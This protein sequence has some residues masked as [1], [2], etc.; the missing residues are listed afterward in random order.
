MFCEV[1][2]TLYTYVG[3]MDYLQAGNLTTV[4]L[5]RDVQVEFSIT[6]LNDDI[7][8]QRDERFNVALLPREDYE[9]AELNE[10]AVFIEDEDGQWGAE[11][12]SPL[13]NNLVVVSSALLLLLAALILSLEMDHYDVS[14]GDGTVTVHAVSSHPAV[15]D[16]LVFMLVADGSAVSEYHTLPT[17]RAPLYIEYSGPLYSTVHCGRPTYLSVIERCPRSG[18]YTASYTG[19]CVPP[20]Y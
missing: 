5:E 18:S 7:P 15:N 9:V 14:E 3:G 13:F 11:S 8:E 10:A 16:T 1:F 19:D 2:L 6:I 17:C 12:L 20:P 4:L